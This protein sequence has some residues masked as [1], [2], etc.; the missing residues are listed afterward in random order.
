[1]V[2]RSNLQRVA[3]P[4]RYR[5]L[6][7]ERGDPFFDRDYNLCVL[8]GRCIRACESLHFT[9]IPTYVKRGSQTRVGTNFGLSHLDAG[10]S[11]CGACVDA[12][13]T[14]ALWEKTRKWDGRPD[15]ETQSTCPF[16]SLGCEIRLVRKNGIVIGALP[17]EG[18][19]ALCV[20]GRFGVTETVNHPGRLKKV[21]RIQN[22]ETVNSNWAEAS[23]LAA[24]ILAGCAPE[25][26]ALVISAN[27]TS[28]DLYI[29]RK[30]GR[31]VMQSAP[32]YLSAATRYGSRLGAAS[33][34]LA[35]SQPLDALDSAD[36]I[37]CLGLDAK[38][39]QSVVEVQL[40]HAKERGAKI[41]TLNA[42]DHVPGRFADLWLKP[43]ANKEKEMLEALTV[44]PIDGNPV[45][46]A[47][48]LLHASSHPVLVVGPDF[49]ASLPDAVEQFQASTGAKLVALAAEGNLAGALRVG[50]GDVPT[51]PLPRVLYLI[52]TALPQ[53]LAQDAFVLVQNTHAL[54]DGLSSGIREGLVLPMAAFSEIDGSLVNQAGKVN[55]LSTVVPPPGDALPGW[56]ILCRIAQ[57]MDKPGFDFVEAAEIRAEM[58]EQVAGEI[59]M[60]GAPDWLVRSGAHDF[61][62]VPLDRWVEGLRGLLPDSHEEEQHA[63]VA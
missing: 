60:D 11:F 7:V 37:F 39:A 51:A 63:P 41:I 6:R 36:L 4:V 21:L 47:L 61:L 27:C 16:C 26:F 52:G 62:G 54:E 50:F 57:A 13:P 2:E 1:M 18:N 32:A 59:E 22:G 35:L 12:C 30:F 17:G 48:L 53:G 40:H 45:E 19:P 23:Q 56:Q 43:Q 42:R 3:Y 29:A 25:D 49:L 14:G 5:G 44:G 20:K 15:G 58:T 38:Y 33:R 34:L 24:E 55:F 9:N 46:E 10:C 28:E 8:C 31:Q